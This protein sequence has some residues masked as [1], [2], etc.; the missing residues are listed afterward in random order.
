MPVVHAELQPQNA[1]GSI[2]KGRFCMDCR[3]KSGN[4][5]KERTGRTKEKIG[6]ETPTDARL[7]CRAL[8]ARPRL[9]TGR[10]TSIGV[11]PRF[12]SQ[13][14]FHRKGPSTRLLLPGTRPNRFCLSVWAGVT[15]PLPVPVQRGHRG[16]VVV[17]GGDHPMPSGSGLQVRARAPHS[18]ARSG[19]A[20]QA[21]SEKSEVRT[22]M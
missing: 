14:A 18:P 17:P 6:G 10:R 3:I 21:A 16:L 19:N 11:P 15:R 13:G 12:S 7:F 22:Y 8:R 4:D 20:S 5:K 2:R 9:P 1:G